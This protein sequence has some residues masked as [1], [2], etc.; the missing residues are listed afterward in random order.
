VINWKAGTWKDGDTITTGHPPR[1]AKVH[2]G[3]WWVNGDNRG[4]F[5]RPDGTLLVNCTLLEARAEARRLFV[6]LRVIFK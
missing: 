2:E 6:T 3:V 5:F 4:V 1:E